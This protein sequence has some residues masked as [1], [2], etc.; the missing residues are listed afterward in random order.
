MN[1]INFPCMTPKLVPIEKLVANGYN[2]NKM[3]S[4]MFRLLKKSITEDGLTMPIVTFYHS[5]KDIYEIVDGFHRYSVLLKMKINEVPVSII[6]KPIE[7]RMMSTIRHNKAK[8]THQ[9]KLIKEIF[10]SLMNS[11]IPLSVIAEGIG[12]EAE[13]VVI[14]QKGA[15]LKEDFK[16][17]KHSNSWERNPEDRI[18]YQ[19][20][21]Q[22]EYEQD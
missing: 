4:K 19:N 17:I 6:D 21:K 5:E 12:A 7:E 15:V 18:L 14:Y 3:E 9:L 1:K 13:E 11:K 10:S 8:G 22:D 16:N 20:K 2:P